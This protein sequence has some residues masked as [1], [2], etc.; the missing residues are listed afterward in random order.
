M[1]FAGGIVI[2]MVRLKATEISLTERV[3]SHL[4]SS[5]EFFDFFK[6]QR[7]WASRSC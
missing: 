4:A 3:Q 5:K 2:P 6:L 1:Q 7:G